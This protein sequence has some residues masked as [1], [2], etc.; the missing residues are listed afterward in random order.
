[1]S[2]FRLYEVSLL[3]VAFAMV[4]VTLVSA[5]TFAVTDR[6]APVIISKVEALNSPLSF[7]ENLSVRIHRDKNRRCPLRSSRYAQSI[8]GKTFDIPNVVSL[9]G[10]PDTQHVDVDYHTA[11]L[12]PGLYTLHVNLLY[13]CPDGNHALMQPTVAFEVVQ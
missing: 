8:T 12:M 11:D 3:T 5:A 4:F 1:M 7:G 9:G 10:D 2:A 6:S 13:L